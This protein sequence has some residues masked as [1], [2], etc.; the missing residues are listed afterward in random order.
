MTSSLAPLLAQREALAQDLA[1]VVDDEV[2]GQT[3][4]SGAAV[5]AAYATVRKFKPGIVATATWHMLPGFL[6]A[7][8]PFWDERGSSPFGEY[9]T[10][11]SEAASEALLAVTD[12][13]AQS[14]AA[15]LAKAYTSLRGKGKGYVAAALGPVGEAIA[16]HAD[17][18][19]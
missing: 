6:D 18:A 17:D 15:P 10:A 5:K 7:L 14:A 19:A 3:G 2:K 13:Q 8:A 16:G 4:M 12:Q 11:H 1:Q 9:L